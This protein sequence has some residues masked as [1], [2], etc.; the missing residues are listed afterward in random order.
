M[1]CEMKQRARAGGV[2]D[3]GIVLVGGD[4]VSALHGGGVAEP[5]G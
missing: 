5:L 3:R 4:M 2:W 1:A